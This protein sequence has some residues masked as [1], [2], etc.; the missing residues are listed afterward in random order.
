[1]SKAALAF[2]HIHIIS[3][4]PEAAA[5][6]YV[7]ML[8]GV[9]TDTYELR[10]APQISVEFDGAVLL[11]RGRRPGEQPGAQPGLTSFGDFASHDQWG[12][13]HF[14]FRV[15][16]DFDKFCRELRERGATFSVDPHEFLPGSPIAYLAAPD[17]VTVELVQAKA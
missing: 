16:G 3:E 9:V 15:T 4:D 11:I 5:A 1:M 6:W 17:G 13:D 12:T 8:G 14:G 2:D 10:G 7:D